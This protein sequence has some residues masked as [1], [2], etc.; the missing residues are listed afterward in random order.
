MPQTIEHA[1]RHAGA[2]RP[3]EADAR[4]WVTA[5]APYREP[6]LARSRVELV[7]T[8]VPFV[9]LWLLRRLSLR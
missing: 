1:D 2:H 9:A 5:L 6:S 8:V 3:A 7:V 4:H